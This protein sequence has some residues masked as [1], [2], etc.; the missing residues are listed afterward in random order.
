MSRRRPVQRPTINDVA[1]LAGVSKATVSRVISGSAPVNEDTAARVHNAINE[2]NYTPSAAAQ[3]LSDQRTNMLG[4]LLL[5]IAAPF[6]VYLLRGIESATRE[7]GFGLLINSIG[8]EPGKFSEQRP[9]LGEHNTDGLI[10]FSGSLPNDELQRLADLGF[11]IVLLHRSAPE[12]LTIPSITVD[13]RTGARQIVE[14]LI[15]V[16]NRRRIA[17]LRGPETEEDSIWREAGYHDALEAYSLPYDPSLIGYGGFDEKTAYHT[18]SRW[19]TEGLE[20][21]AVFSGD[22]EAGAGVLNALH[23]VGCRMPE[24][25]SVVGFDDDYLASRLIPGLTTV[26]SPIEEIGYE[27]VTQLI[28]LIKGK[29]AESKILPTRLVI[30]ASC[31]CTGKEA[32]LLRDY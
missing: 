30:R 11:P 10:V 18:V 22:D 1:Q 26:H 19:L 24:D 7:S 8:I 4:L 17:F 29:P 6:F 25:V 12:G 20:F 13:N 9:F 32:G 28:R 14:H 16:H 31:G 27:A 23:D 3:A 15:T 5:E 2:L 21:D